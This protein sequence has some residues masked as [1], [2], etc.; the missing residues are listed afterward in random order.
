MDPDAQE[1]FFDLSERIFSKKMDSWSCGRN[2]SYQ[3]CL[4]DC[5]GEYQTGLV[6]PWGIYARFGFYS[7]AGTAKNPNVYF[8]NR[9]A[10]VILRPYDPLKSGSVT[11]FQSV[12]CVHSSAAFEAPAEPFATLTYSY[13]SKEMIR[14]G[15]ALGWTDSIFI[16]HGLTV[17]LYQGQNFDGRSVTI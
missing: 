14:K 3:F 5:S 8:T 9:V 10:S 16:P 12:N 6:C 13:S 2:V 11:L 15:M 1:S 4:D 17:T 7:G